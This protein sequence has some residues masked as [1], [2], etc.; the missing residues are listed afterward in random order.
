MFTLL[1]FCRLVN[2]LYK[3]LKENLQYPWG[4]SCKVNYCS[5]DPSFRWR[6]WLIT[7]GPGHVSG[8]LQRKEWILYIIY[9]KG[10][11][12]RWT[13]SCSRRVSFSTCL[14][15]TETL[16]S[17]SRHVPFLSWHLPQ[18]GRYTEDE[19]SQVGFPSRLC[20]KGRCPRSCGWTSPDR[21]D[22]VVTHGS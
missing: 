13:F 17:P 15:P 7:L 5:L 18:T 21:K 16:P 14:F 1:P 22:V 10:L 12:G 6:Q 9:Y 4:L 19:T 11:V 20:L 8:R 2:V 3:T